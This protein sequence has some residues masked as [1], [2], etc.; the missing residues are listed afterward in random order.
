MSDLNKL[1]RDLPADV[2][3]EFSELLAKKGAEIQGFLFDLDKRLTNTNFLTNGGGAVAVLTFMGDK[4]APLSVKIALVLF[5][6]GVIA[7]GIE[8]RAML[9][10][11]DAIGQENHRRF[12]AFNANEIPASELGNL[13]PDLAKWSKIVNHYAGLLSQ[14]L[15]IAGVT[16]GACGFLGGT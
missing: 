13:P 1:R 12:R 5:S 16:M 11:F 14:G 4:P 3:D 10:C 9:K 6:L 8:L 15:F 2:S 7:T